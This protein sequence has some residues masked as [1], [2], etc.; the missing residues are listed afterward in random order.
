MDVRLLPLGA[1]PSVAATGGSSGALHRNRPGA[2]YSWLEVYF[3]IMLRVT[4]VIAALWA[5]RSDRPPPFAVLIV[6]RA[7]LTAVTDRPLTVCRATL[8]GPVHI[9]RSLV[10]VYSL[11]QSVHNLTFR[12]RVFL[13]GGGRR[14][15]APCRHNL[16]EKFVGLSP[17]KVDFERWHDD[18]GEIL[19]PGQVLPPVSV[20]HF[21]AQFPPFRPF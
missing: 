15:Q 2:A 6:C 13:G 11:V 5:H 10:A 14:L 21:P 3:R 7:F 16:V 20:R 8:S 12:P 1:T 17:R 4:C 19:P 9:A 18:G